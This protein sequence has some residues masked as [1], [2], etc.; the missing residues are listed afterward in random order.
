TLTKV[1]GVTRTFPYSTNGTITSIGG[2]CGTSAGDAATVDW[3]I[4]TQSGTTACSSGS[5]SA[6]ITTISADGGYTAS[7]TQSDAAGNNGSSGNKSITLDTI[8][9]TNSLSLASQTGGS[10]LT[11]TTLYYQGSAAGSFR[12]Q[13]AVADSGSGPDSSQFGGLGGTST[14]WTFTGS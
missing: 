5:W 12:I 9:P 1:N 4:G 14:G 6:S 7:G 11:G 2:A 13:N 10:Y 3:S 8:Q